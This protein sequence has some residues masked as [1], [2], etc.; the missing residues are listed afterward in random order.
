MS[1][2]RCG[3]RTLRGPSSALPILID[4]VEPDDA[5]DL[6]NGLTATRCRCRDTHSVPLAAAVRTYSQLLLACLF[7]GGIVISKETNGGSIYY[8]FSLCVIRHRASHRNSY[9]IFHSL[10][11]SLMW[12]GFRWCFTAGIGITC[13]LL[14]LGP[15]RVFPSSE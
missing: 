12:N 14:I 11:Q 8:L 10:K 5:H 9:H 15:C 4:G 3:S 1:I 2:S 13:C 6:C 7:G